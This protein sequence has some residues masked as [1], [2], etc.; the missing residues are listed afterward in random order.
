[1]TRSE[2]RERCRVGTSLRTAFRLALALGAAIVAT[3]PAQA[4]TYSVIHNFMG[5][6]DGDEPNYGLTIDAGGNLYGTTFG[7]DSG[8]GTAYMLSPQS[9]GWV[10]TPLYQ[11]SGGSDGAAPYAAVVFGP[12][13]SLYGTTGFG[14]VPN[15]ACVTGGGFT[16][17]GVVFNL[18]NTSGSWTESPI[19]DFCPSGQPP[20]SDGADPYGARLVFDQ[21]GN[22]Y[23][24]TFNGGGGSCTGGVGGCGVV[25]QLTPSGGGWT[26]SVLYAFNGGS[27]GAH[28]W[29]GVIFDQSGNLYGTTEFGGGSSNCPGGCGVVYELVPS[30]GSWTEKVLYTFQNQQDGAAPYA[31]LIFDQSGNLYGA[32]T[33]G[34]QH[35]GGTAF[36]L[37]PSGEGWSFQTL[38]AFTAYGSGIAG[39]PTASLVMDNAGNLYGATAGDGVYSDGA[40]FKLISAGGGWTYSSLH[41]LT[42]NDDGRLPRSN[43]VFDQYGNV[44]GT[45]GGGA[46]GDGLAFQAAAGL[47]YVPLSPCRVVDTRNGIPIQ[48]GTQQN[49]PIQGSQGKC[50]NI[51]SSA[52]AYS[53]NVTVVPHE[54]LGYLTV[55]PAGQNQ[56]VISTLNSVDGR[57][58]AV[59]AIVGAGNTDNGAVSVYA[60]NTTDLILDLDGYFAPPS[61]STLAFYPLAPC[62]VLDTRQSGQYLMGGQ[63]YTYPVS[64]LCNVP[65][66]GAAAYSLNFTALPHEPLGY[67]SAWPAGQPQP[68]AS[69][70]NAP[71][72]VV[73]AN[74]A[75]T[76]AGTGGD[77]DVLASNDTDLLIDVNGYFAAPNSGTAPLSLYLATPCR[78]LDTRQ[79]NGAFEGQL[80]VDVFGSQCPTTQFQTTAQAYVLNA[81]VLPQGPLGYL[82]LWANGAPQPM[83][84]TLNAVDGV[85]TSNMAVVPTTN[86][87]IDAYASSYTQL[88]LDISAYFAP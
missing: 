30:Q 5:G 21:A 6:A 2:R 8:Q 25:Y 44:Y 3:H 49:F 83:A 45:A 60:S 26:E 53:F 69:I 20:C 76:Q 43:L 84:S 75:L 40:V 48:G 32:T 82:T 12:D 4:Q 58:K 80:P 70:L 47:Q 34:G 31:G 14:G 54:P 62:R 57:T 67:L 88:L 23:G 63:Q 11:F 22:L 61:S 50:T 68:L 38:Y 9:S 74:A 13:G 17:C 72:G 42:S 66:S 24:T 36:E 78:V 79:G 41:D 37:T 71:T 87:S 64:G 7:G 85:I 35:G 10:L 56:P 1:M 27:D 33:Q 59:A 81:T 77:I 29:A 28:P 51:P 15:P 86:G 52:V 55:W 46:D 19:Y 16:G 73:T 18:K 65:A 39:G